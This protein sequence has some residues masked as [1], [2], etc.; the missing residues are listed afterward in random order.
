[1]VDFD[2]NSLSESV[3]HV[4][5]DGRDVYLVGTAHV[6]IESVEDVRKTIEAVKPDS[7]CVELCQGR[8]N[9]M[10]Q[11]DA[12]KNMNIFKV[13]KEK[14][15]VLLLAQLIMS[16]FYRRLG[17]K[18]GIKPGAEMVEGMKLA[19]KTGAKLVLA[20][21]DIQITLK[22]VWGYL[23]LWN[24]MKLTTQLVASLFSSEKIDAELIEEIKNKDQ[25]ESIMEEFTKAFPEVKRRLIDERDIYLA[26]KIRQAQGQK[27]VAVVGA[28]HIPGIKQHI[29]KD[30]SLEELIKIPRKSI[31]PT[32][33]KWVIPAAIIS[34]FIVGFLKSGAEHS[35]QS[36]WIW[37]LV[38]GT[39]SAA[40]AAIALGHPLTI[41]ASFVGA[42]LTSLNPMIAAGW[43]AGLVQAFVRQP[44]VADFENL[45]DAISTVKGFW[46]NPVIKVLLVIILA[47]VGSSLGTFIS[48]GWIASRTF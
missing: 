35:M 14:K 32:L 27:I 26:Q 13:I 31:F 22:R 34:L 18:L 16:A 19:E 24:K 17:K 10:T 20:D 42:P 45:H 28:G 4:V 29:H 21:R 41:L 8:Y 12:W 23:G 39:L 33:L 37:V 38:N 30:E 2:E 15:G 1:M 11:Q 40:G 48:G 6:S 25:L 47:N 46:T 3:S 5:V 43:V 9:T 7:I 36:I 44:T